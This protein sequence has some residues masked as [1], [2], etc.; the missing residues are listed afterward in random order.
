MAKRRPATRRRNYGNG[1]GYY[2]DGDYLTGRGVTTLI[3]NGYP[4]GALQ[5]W[6]AKEVATAAVFE[7]DIWEPIF[8]RSKDAAIEYLKEAPFR[9]RDAAAN[10]GTEV[11]RIAER[12]ADGEEVDVPVELEGYVDSY[13]DF[14]EDWRPV[15]E[16]VEAV[17]I[18]RT[19]RYMG[20]ADL[21]ATFEGW[22]I[23]DPDAPG[24]V[25]PARVLADIKTSRS[26]IYPE[27]AL[28]IAAYRNAE[29][30]IDVEATIPEQP[31]PV[32]DRCAA[33]HIRADG[34]DLFPINA[35]P[36]VFRMFLY[37]AQVAA[38]RGTKNDPGP[39][40]ALIGKPIRPN[41]P[42]QELTP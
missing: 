34:Y 36:D 3:G 6:A 31:I 16:V 32:V 25:R 19:H 15:D 2:L 41:A 7:R 29:H 12:L 37:V 28:Q 9:D 40:E 4:K 8:G 26:G 5:Y 23:E 24:G 22:L 13:L 17:V 35:G 27:T 42:T 20:T 30:Y 10:R 18:N 38:F 33:I 1:H 21:F 11:H 39:A 14:R